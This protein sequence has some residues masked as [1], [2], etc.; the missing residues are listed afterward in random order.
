MRRSGARQRLD[1]RQRCFGSITLCCFGDNDWCPDTPE[2]RNIHTKN[3]WLNYC[4]YL[5]LS[6]NQHLV[7]NRK[8]RAIGRRKTTGLKQS[9]GLPQ[10][11]I[12]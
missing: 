6:T 2:R 3:S 7:K 11:E 1:S 8:P 10:G 9:A 12:K 4:F 5:V